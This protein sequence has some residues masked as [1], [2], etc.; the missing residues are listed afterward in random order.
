MARPRVGMIVLGT[1]GVGVVVA[2]ARRGRLVV[3]GRRVPGGI[4]MGDAGAYDALSRLLFGSLFRAIAADIAAVAPT[5]GRVLEVGCGPGHLS[6]RLTLDHGLDVTGL[7]LDPE[8]IERAR[9]NAEGSVDTDE[10]GPP[11]IVGDVASLPFDGGS[12]DLVVSTFSMHHWPDVTSGL[13]EIA[14]VL[15]PGGRALVWDFKA[16]FRLFHTSLPDPAEPAHGSALRVASVTPWQW[17]WRL[18]L[19]QRVEFVHPQRGERC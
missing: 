9:A 5:G 15:R 17:P 7:D 8:M 14:R 6:I 12:F 1:L 16:G 18:T 2:I 13:N 4:V 19:A 10:Q 11:F 3:T